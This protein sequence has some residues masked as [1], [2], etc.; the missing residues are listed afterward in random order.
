ML[1][2]L[3]EHRLVDAAG[4]GELPV[5]VARQCAAGEPP[6]QP[7]QRRV[8]R[9]RVEPED[10]RRVVVE[11]GEIGDP[12]EVEDRPAAA[13]LLAASPAE[14]HRI[15]DRR[16][17]RTLA[18]GG[19]VAGAEVGDHGAPRPDRDHVAV[20]DLERRPDRPGDAAVMID[21]LAVRADDVDVI[22]TDSRLLER[23]Q[24]GRGERL[25]DHDVQLGDAADV[26]AGDADEPPL[27]LGVVR[28]LAI[29]QQLD[30]RPRP[31]A[32]SSGR[33]PRRSSR[34]SCPDIRPTTRREGLRLRSRR[35][36][37]GWIMGSYPNQDTAVLVL[38]ECSRFPGD[39]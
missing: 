2:Q 32:P 27:D 23:R 33:R 1:E 37:N 21:R 34:R 13:R 14:Q 24:A 6:R 4:P 25:A 36:A 38:V 28:V 5:A 20:A 12:A 18:A 22:G 8:R 39:G 31:P 30:R 29:V 19:D 9:A 15:G 3:G 7:V 17:R 35:S 11:H 26:E 16:Q 10:P